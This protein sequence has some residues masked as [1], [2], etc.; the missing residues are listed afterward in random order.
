MLWPVPPLA[1]A[2]VPARVITPELIT[3]PPEVVRPVVP[4]DTSTET[5]V[6]VPEI[7][8]YSM[9]VPVELTTTTLPLLPAKVGKTAVRA[10][11]AVVAPV[12]PL[13]SPTI[14]ETLVAVPV[15]VPTKLDDVTLVS[16]ARVVD[17]APR[18]ML[19]D[20]MVTVELVRLP[21][22]MF[23]IVFSD[24]LIVVPRIVLLL[25]VRPCTLEDAINAVPV[26]LTV[27]SLL[28][29]PVRVGSRAKPA[30]IRFSSLRRLADEP[31]EFGVG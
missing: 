21:G 6:P 31:G 13:T 4:P 17:V 19:V 14:P 5:T 1:A 20:P 11:R 23:V 30:V 16:P 26:E 3:G 15:R 24:P 8:V 28:A 18:A 29:F 7:V 10:P 9:S 12:P 25:I 27:A 2:K 22:P